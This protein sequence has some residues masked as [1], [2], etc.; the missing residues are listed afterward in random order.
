[1]NGSISQKRETAAQVGTVLAGLFILFLVKTVVMSQEMPVAREPISLTLIEPPV[2]P[3]ITKPVQSVPPP[4]PEKAVEPARAVTPVIA[5]PVTVKD[6]LVAL[7]T[8]PEENIVPPHIEPQI[9]RVSNGVAEGVFAQ[10]VRSRIER[11]KIY[12]DTAR[13]LGM[14]GEV[15]VM[16]ELDRSGKLLRAE[17]VS[18]SGF[19]LLDQS[20]LRAVKSASYQ[21]FPQDAWIGANSK[22][23]RTKLV[24]SINQ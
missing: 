9:Q 23:F 24:F 16:Y 8:A 5:A 6:Q 18:S 15:E 1:M 11:K 2:E 21:S 14:S 4:K 20:A 10:D 19:N 13:D 17:I 22:L 3:E 7:V 12:P